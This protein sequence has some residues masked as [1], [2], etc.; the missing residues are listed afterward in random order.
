MPK[1]DGA[2]IKGWIDEM[3]IIALR[4]MS[5]VCGPRLAEGIEHEINMKDGKII[6]VLEYKKVDGSD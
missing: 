6:P 1:D 3:N 2:E 4:L 5:R